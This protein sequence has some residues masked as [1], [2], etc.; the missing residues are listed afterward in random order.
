VKVD[1]RNARNKKTKKLEP[2]PV[3]ASAHD[4]RRAF[5]ERWAH[6]VPSMIL[7][8]L[9]RH[10]SVVTTEKYYV[11][12]NAKKTLATLRQ[13]KSASEVNSEVNEQEKGSSK[14]AETP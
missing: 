12:I 2:R 1:Q 13:Y 11:G 5:G 6:L 9:M 4:L 8:D 3:F 14:I 7:R 10:A